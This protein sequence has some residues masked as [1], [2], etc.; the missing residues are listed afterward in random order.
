[1]PSIMPH[2]NGA[3]P[4]RFRSGSVGQCPGRQEHPM[5]KRD[6]ASRGSGGSG[7]RATSE[8]RRHTPTDIM[9]NAAEPASYRM[10]ERSRRSTSPTD[11]RCSMGR[12]RRT[13][14]FTA[15]R[16]DRL[17][18]GGSPQSRQ[19]RRGAVQ[20]VE[21]HFCRYPFA[22]TTNSPTPRRAAD[23]RWLTFF[24]S[25]GEVHAEASIGPRPASPYF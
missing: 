11:R 3:K 13:A 23:S 2:V 24:A 9:V 8:L 17:A 14:L 18:A 10:Q 6:S 25:G 7:P 20:P 1:M 4:G 22:T 15:D 21:T 16:W 19:S 5:I 12:P